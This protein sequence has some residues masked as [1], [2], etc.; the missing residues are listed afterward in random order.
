MHVQDGDEHHIAARYVS[1]FLTSLKAESLL[2]VGSGTGRAIRFF[3]Q[4]NPA[5]R[6]IGVEPVTALIDEARAKGVAEECMIQGYGEALPFADG[7]FDAVCEFGAL[8]HVAN[9]N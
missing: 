6:V 7:S 4:A 5:L 8:H 1:Q 9:P 3:R 2:D